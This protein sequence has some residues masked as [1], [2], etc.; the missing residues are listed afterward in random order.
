MKKTF[1]T[2]STTSI[3]TVVSLILIVILYIIA[4]LG[5]NLFDQH[6][7]SYETMC[8]VLGVILT[9]IVTVVL[10]KGQAESEEKKDT[11]L[12]I[13][14]KKQEVYHRFLEELQRIIQDGEITISGKGQQLDAEKNVDKLKDLIFQLG[15][16]QLHTKTEN[17][18][19]IFALTG[20]IVEL[21]KKFSSSRENNP[22]QIANYYAALCKN[23]FGI[24][25]ILKEDL[26]LTQKETD[27]NIDSDDYCPILNKFGLS[28]N[29]TRSIDKYNA[30]KSFWNELQDQLKEKGYIKEKRDFNKDV[31]KYYAHKRNRHRYYG[32]E[33]EICKTKDGLPVIFKVEIDNEYFYGIHRPKENFKD[34]R[35]IECIKTAWGQDFKE[36]SWWFARKMP[37]RYRLDFWNMTGFQEWNKT[38]NIEG[39]VDEI[40]GYIQRFV[41]VAK[42]KNL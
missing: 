31:D 13:F 34:N 32:V 6:D 42:S 22:E 23:I 10:L 5:T 37:N 38:H 19:N 26:Y 33:F 16:I 17:V 11:N 39:I 18:K 29:D 3:I 4:V 21:M 9:A 27:K 20:E 2:I 36:D 30:Q 1:Y 15:Y 7:I 12:K 35:I 25:S 41:E 28:L 8:A 40:D 24:V 14:E